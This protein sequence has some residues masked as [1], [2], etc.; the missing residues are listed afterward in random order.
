MKLAAMYIYNEASERNKLWYLLGKAKKD[1]KWC[2]VFKIAQA[3]DSNQ[4]SILQIR[5]HFTNTFC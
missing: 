4:K 5:K 3:V 1:W 2:G